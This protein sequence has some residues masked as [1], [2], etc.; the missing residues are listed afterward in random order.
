MER[1]GDREK[2]EILA[3]HA[4]G[5]TD[6]PKGIYRELFILMNDYYVSWE[7]TRV[8]LVH[9]KPGVIVHQR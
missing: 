5:M 7:N 3:A 9:W 1:A 6:A 4:G 2:P 8:Q